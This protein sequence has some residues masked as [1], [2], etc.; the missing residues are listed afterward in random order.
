MS[1]HLGMHVNRVITGNFSELKQ[2]S[3]EQRHHAL[4]ER[5]PQSLFVVSPLHRN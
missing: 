3:E 2:A 1:I 4:R 5:F